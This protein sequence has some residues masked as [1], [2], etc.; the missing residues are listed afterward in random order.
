MISD[1]LFSYIITCIQNKLM[2]N[3]SEIFKTIDL[4]YNEPTQNQNLMKIGTINDTKEIKDKIH[5]CII[6][7]IKTIDKILDGKK[8]N[9]YIQ[10]ILKDNRDHINNVISMFDV[11]LTDT[12]NYDKSTPSFKELGIGKGQIKYNSSFKL[13]LEYIKIQ[14]TEF[15]K[16][17][18]KQSITSKI[19]SNIPKILLLRKKGGKKVSLVKTKERI[20]VRYENKKY[21]RNILIRKNKKYV[22]IN[23]KY[24]RLI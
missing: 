11:F 3:M 7:I 16:N 9:K 12:N 4:D 19:T 14:L 23:N 15:S 17:L 5:I 21:K 2:Y 10:K 22:K 8:R 24:I 13:N 20:V 6:K 18:S 1:I